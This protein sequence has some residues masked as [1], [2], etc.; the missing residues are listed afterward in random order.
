MIRAL[1]A[2]AI[3]ICAL[4]LAACGGGGGGG[5]SNTPPPPAQTYTV[6]VTVSGL[7]GSGL[8]LNDN[9]ADSLT[10]KSNGVATFAT[11]LAGGHAYAVTVA[12]QPTSPAQTCTVANGSGSIGSA[13][14]TNVTVSCVVAAFP[15]NVTVS[16]LTGSGLVLQNNFGDDLPVSAS[17][18]VTFATPVASGN[19]YQVVV[20][21]QP[22]NP[23]QQCTVTNGSGTVTNGP[24]TT[25]SV[26]CVA[27]LPAGMLT[28]NY[29]DGSLSLYLVDG[30]TGQP[31]ARGL[32]RVGPGPTFAVDD[33]QGRYIYVLNSLSTI[34]AFKGDSATMSL[35]PI[36]NYQAG[37]GSNSM[38]VSPNGQ[39]I[40]VSNGTSGDISAFTI[41]GST[42]T[43]TAVPGSPFK[44]GTNP[45]SV[46]AD[47]AGHFAY[48]VNT[49]SDDIYTYSVD[50]TSGA[51]TEVAN[52][53]V[54][55]GPTPFD[56]Q[57]HRTGK[58]AYIA[59][60]GSAL[61]TGFQVNA[62]TGVLS[63]IPGSPFATSGVPGDT[64][65]F[66]GNREPLLLHPNGKLLFVRSTQAK[67]V[68]VMMIDQVT[69]A[70]TPAADGPHAVGDGAVGIAL[71]PTGQFLYV[72]NHG[73]S[74]GLSGS[75]SAFKVNA[76][77]GAL[78]E[79][80]GS[81]FALNGA[82]SSV[83][84]D[85]SGK[86]LF[87]CSGTTDLVYGMNIDQATGALTPLASGAR[88]VTGDGPIAVGL[89]SDF[90][91][92]VPNTYESKRLY[93]PNTSDQ[94]ITG[95][96]ADPTTGALSPMAGS[97]FNAT[98]SGLSSLAIHASNKFVYA[99][100]ATSGDVSQYN[101]DA[102]SGALS[103]SAN[104]P[105]SLGTGAAPQVFATDIVS[106]FAYVLDSGNQ[107]IAPF[108]LDSVTGALNANLLLPVNTGGPPSGLVVSS[109]GRFAVSINSTAL[110]Y[111]SISTGGVIAGPQLNPVFLA[112]APSSVVIHP[113]GYFVYVSRP[114]TPGAIDA[115]PFSSFSGTPLTPSTVAAGAAPVAMA[116]EATGHF[117]YS[118]N[119]GSNDISIFSIDQLTGELTAIASTVATGHHPESLIADA[120]GRFL[121]ATNSGDQN[122]W[123]YSINGT[124][125]ALTPVG[126]PVATGNSPGAL[127]ASFDVVIH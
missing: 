112:S 81:P 27:R 58:F 74:P 87:A 105:T 26:S 94:T 63:P 71:D 22:S 17:G 48:V 109:S 78:T 107:K 68:S 64:T 80:T 91:T 57:L 10:V 13:N 86:F 82:P 3:G 106:Q 43:L 104:A 32:T 45:S 79:V 67:T 46:L 9:G 113:N 83:T 25:L 28:I 24:I 6:A 37:N 69:G 50:A 21:A 31:R 61:I 85:P 66:N 73:S 44:A 1:A 8:V 92:T 20:L 88:L 70:L 84:V 126:S 103:P 5:G 55:A 75:I 100:N 77:S 15:V 14:V 2:T 36:A 110:E 124:T 52:S 18:T 62:T 99:T 125:G 53:R 40:Y 16:G 122:T 33:G 115:V 12:T 42:G 34:S 120:S 90:G 93:V 72:A 7:T 39:T 54:S 98:G 127:A 89:R 76:S 23:V 97:P 123:T 11:A 59:S 111:Y 60:V 47:A 49:G 119:S 108:T 102:T 35:L 56:L 116:I 38:I 118:A 95:Y 114:T 30:V 96:L 65:P 4:G 121:Y 29:N 51:L 19:P 41:V 117:L 101:I